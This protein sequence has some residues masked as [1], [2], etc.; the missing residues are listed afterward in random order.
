MWLK[1]KGFFLLWHKS[2]KE[3]CQITHLSIFPFGD[4]AQDQFTLSQPLEAH[5][6][7]HIAMSGFSDLATAQHLGSY[8]YSPI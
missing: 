7:H 5:Y 4:S 2:Q 1:F 6:A 8:E 3:R